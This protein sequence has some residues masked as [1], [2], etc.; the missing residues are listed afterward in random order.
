ML[1]IL[2]DEN[3]LK[4][5]KICKI[6]KPKE[7]YYKS[8]TYK[9]G[10]RPECIKCCG[11]KG[12]KYPKT[13]EQIRA[14]RLKTAYGITLEDFDKMFVEQGGVCAICK[15]PQTVENRKGVVSHLCVDHC[16]KTGKVRGLLC[17][18]CNKG[19]GN[20]KESKLNLLRAIE[21]LEKSEI[22]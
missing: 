8:N 15:L 20:L 14:S 3:G 19:I 21:Y 22:K 9:S 7:D 11:E 16:H 6:K 18:N 12:K 5:C 13:K 10:Y 2:F 17:N 4:E 1:P